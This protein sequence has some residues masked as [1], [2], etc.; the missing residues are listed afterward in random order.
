L[1]DPT[2]G[3]LITLAEKA[4]INKDKIDNT[5]S[6]L[7]ELPFDSDRKMMT[8]F[9][10]DYI[11]NKVLSFTKGAPDIIIDRCSHI[12]IGG[13]VLP[14]DDK[15]KQDVIDANASFSKD[16]LRVL[17]FAYREYS[18]LPED[19]SS[20]ANENQM[21]FV[22]LVGIIDPP[23]A[24]VK[25]AIKLCKQA[26]IDTIM[27]TG[28]HRDTAFAIAKE[29]GMADSED[30]VMV[31]AELD[32]L[33]DEELQAIIEDIRVYARVSPEHKVRIIS[34]LK[35]DGHITAMTGD[36]VNDALALKKADIGISMGITG[37]DVAKDTAELIL[38][39]DNFASIVAAVEEGR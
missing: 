16:A 30:Q 12:N 19:I 31:G 4:N 38:T 15:L 34:A 5:Y 29:L 21:V 14:L 24:E 13:K 18:K 39:D 9:H 7:D 25:E 26:G 23:R 20:E 22:G 6:R 1:G 11:P 36:G 32:K 17:A 2:E 10:R 37:T 33:S 28:D 35:N 8:T 27:I 3:A